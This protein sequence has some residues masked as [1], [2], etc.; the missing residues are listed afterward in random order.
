[1]ST[2]HVQLFGKCS[3]QTSAHSLIRLEAGK[4][5]DLLCYLLLYRERPHAR[6]V[7]A[8]LFWGDSTTSQSKKYLRQALWQLQNVL[9]ADNNATGDALLIIDAEWIT[10][11]LHAGFWLDVD[12]F[13]QAFM[14]TCGIEGRNLSDAQVH[15][16][17]EAVHLYRGDLL[18][19]SFQDWCIYER[20]RLQRLYLA[21]LDKLMSYHESHGEY[22]TALEYGVRNLRCDPARERTHRQMMRLYYLVGDRTAALRQYKRC[23]SALAE[24]LDVRPSRQTELLYQLIRDD[25]LDHATSHTPILPQ[26]TKD[27]SMQLTDLLNHLQHLQRVLSIAQNDVC[28]DIQV[29]EL[30]MAC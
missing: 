9:E 10:I 24:E 21:I 18:E 25:A 29:L 30:A 11:H 7:L 17:C 20:E 27:R 14:K 23:C 15:T 19:G 1:M 2:M 26:A 8:S 28:R 6:E 4:V 12:I 16:L 5:Q 22:E 13:E 3:L